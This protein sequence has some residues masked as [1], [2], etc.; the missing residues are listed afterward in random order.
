M[1]TLKLLK[2]FS[3]IPTAAAR[4]TT[5]AVVLRNK[6]IH[7]TTIVTIGLGTPQRTLWKNAWNSKNHACVNVTNILQQNIWQNFIISFNQISPVHNLSSSTEEISNIDKMTTENLRC[8]VPPASVRGMKV[9]NK[10]AF[11]ITAQIPALYIPNEQMHKFVKV[12]KEYFF[13]RPGINPIRDPP[14]D[15]HQNM[16]QILFHPEKCQSVQDLPELARER[17]KE[18]GIASDVEFD[19]LDVP[20]TYDNWKYDEILNAV[21]PEEEQKVAGFS[22]IGHI[23]HLNLKEHVL[24]Y[25]SIIG[26]FIMIPLKCAIWANNGVDI[27]GQVLFEK[28]NNVKTVVNKMQTID[29]TFR[30]FSMEV[31]AGEDNF[32][33]ICK[34]NGCQYKMDFSQVFWNPRL[35]KRIL[36]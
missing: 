2:N 16:K 34:E 8:L 9:L 17:L 21:L 31:L 6:I 20:I 33:T 10:E 1:L 25:K 30:N 19:F 27:T 11:S 4:A 18:L 7:Q 24:E 12:A 32:I 15:M 35:G 22:I 3:N 29:N 13:K 36:N 14:D 5:T 26:E 28:L 23:L